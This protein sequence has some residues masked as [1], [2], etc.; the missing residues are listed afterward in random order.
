VNDIQLPNG[1]RAKRVIQVF[2][3]ERDGL[4]IAV[5][6]VDGPPE[7]ELVKHDLV[8]VANSVEA[9]LIED[10]VTKPVDRA[11]TEQAIRNL[12]RLS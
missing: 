2:I 4:H 7:M 3:G 10:T 6:G 5:D 8:R 1:Q 12:S 9:R 11:L